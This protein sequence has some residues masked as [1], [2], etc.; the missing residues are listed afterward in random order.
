MITV[1]FLSTYKTVVYGKMYRVQTVC[2]YF[3]MHIL[4]KTLFTALDI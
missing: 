2:V 4:F 1:L 3:L